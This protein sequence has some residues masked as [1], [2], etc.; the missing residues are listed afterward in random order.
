MINLYVRKYSMLELMTEWNWKSVV[1]CDPFN[2]HIV[3]VR[4]KVNKTK[5]AV[6]ILVLMFLKMPEVCNVMVQK[7]I[8]LGT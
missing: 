4:L 7:A 1:F 5:T 2:C 8:D 6:Y 3:V